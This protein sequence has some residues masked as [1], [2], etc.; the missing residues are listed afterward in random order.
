MPRSVRAHMPEGSDKCGKKE[1]MLSASGLTASVHVASKVINRVDFATPRRLVPFKVCGLVTV[2]KR[3]DHD[4]QVL[5]VQTGAI[6]DS[7]FLNNTASTGQG[8]AVY[9]QTGLIDVVNCRC[10]PPPPRRTRAR[11]RAP[12][13]HST[14]CD[15]VI[16]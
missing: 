9:L 3:Q 14:A 15:L 5:A 11:A 16:S 13:R 7:D 6:G 10:P 12:A 8:G 2:R 4:G 1:A